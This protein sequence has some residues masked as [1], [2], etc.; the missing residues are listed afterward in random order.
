MNLRSLPLPCIALIAIAGSAHAAP[1]V[2][3]KQL[4]VGAADVQ[5]LG[6]R[7]GL[8]GDQGHGEEVLVVE[9]LDHAVGRRAD[10]DGLGRA[11]AVAADG[12]EQKGIGDGVHAGN[13]DPVADA[14]AEEA[15]PALAAAA[16]ATEA[17]RR[18]GRL[19]VAIVI[20]GEYKR[21]HRRRMGRVRE[22]ELLDSAEASLLHWDV[23][24]GHFVPNLS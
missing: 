3:G 9:V 17:P 1:Q 6:D 15:G 2:N 7:I 4:T 11:G 19:A 18:R 21:S 24:D 23:M 5:Q 14:V 16:P 8:A 20:G 12:V 22:I 10:S 13:P